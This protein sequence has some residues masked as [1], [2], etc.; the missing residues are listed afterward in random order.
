M[1]IPSNNL[2]QLPWKISQ[3]SLRHIRRLLNKNCLPLLNNLNIQFEHWLTLLQLMA[4]VSVSGR[5]R[6]A[7]MQEVKQEQISAHAGQTSAGNPGAKLR[8]TDFFKYLSARIYGK[9]D[10]SRRNLPQQ[11]PLDKNESAKLKNC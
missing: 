8:L 2:K 5:R 7:W 4:P 3:Q 10:G 6:L 1:V 11:R 9:I